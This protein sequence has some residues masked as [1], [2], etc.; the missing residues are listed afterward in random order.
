AVEVMSPDDQFEDVVDKISDYFEAGT[1]EVW[2]VLP[3][4]KA[5]YRYRRGE[6]QVQTYRESDSMDVSALFPGLT[7]ALVDIFKL[8]DL[9]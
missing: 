6:S 1:A 4:Q 9:G 8:P 5:L 3:R 2:V 7:L